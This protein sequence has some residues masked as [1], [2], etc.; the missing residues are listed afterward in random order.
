MYR[1]TNVSLPE[2]DKVG[3]Q[4]LRESNCST[5]KQDKEP[6]HC[7]IKRKDVEK[8]HASSLANMSVYKEMADWA[9]DFVYKGYNN[10]AT[11]MS[12]Y[13]QDPG[14]RRQICRSLDVKNASVAISLLRR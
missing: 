7:I 9:P 11:R 14:L 2:A 3:P 12:K 5:I 6:G 4:M 10:L 13:D 8:A 1:H